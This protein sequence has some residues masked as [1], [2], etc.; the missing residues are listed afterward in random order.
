[1]VKDM[2]SFDHGF[3]TILQKDVGTVGAHAWAAATGSWR[4]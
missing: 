3:P 4:R 1:M 2:T